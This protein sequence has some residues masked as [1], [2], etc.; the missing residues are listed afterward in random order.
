LENVESLISILEAAFGDPNQVGT[1]SAE[2][3]KRMQGNKD[4]S[5]YYAEFQC[6]MAIL[7]DDSNAKKA[8]LKRCLSEELQTSLVHQAEEPQDF[9][10][11][12]D[13]CMKLDNR[14]HTHAVATKRQTTP[15]PPQTSPTSTRPSAYPTSTNSRNYGV[16]PMDVSASQKAQ[17]QRRRDERMA[18]GLCL[19]CGSTDHFKNECLALAANNSRKVHLATAEISMTSTDPAPTSEPSSGK[20]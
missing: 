3:D 2:L 11:F 13:L 9:A 18:K 10:K 19:Y 15:A 17:N 14:I 4:F 12:V 20:E 8:T 6:L 7:D 16:A 1:A 5:Q